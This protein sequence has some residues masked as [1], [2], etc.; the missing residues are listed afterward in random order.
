MEA[1]V[2][3]TTSPHLPSRY[4][5]PNMIM[6]VPSKQQSTTQK[7]STFNRICPLTSTS[8]RTVCCNIIGRITYW[9]THFYYKRHKQ[10]SFW[11]V[12]PCYDYSEHCKEAQERRHKDIHHCTH[13]N[14]NSLGVQSLLENKFIIYVMIVKPNNAMDNSNDPLNY[15][16]KNATIVKYCDIT[17]GSTHFS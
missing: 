5:R 14:D 7:L 17:S 16:K 2:Y 1:V 15:I 3:A 12:L 10:W 13:A 6:P 4:K 9:P 8:M 11:K